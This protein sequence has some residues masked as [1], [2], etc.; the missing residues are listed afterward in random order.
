MGIKGALLS[1]VSLLSRHCFEVMSKYLLAAEQRTHVLCQVFHCSEFSSESHSAELLVHMFDPHYD[2]QT[3]GMSPALRR[4][5][6]E[7]NQTKTREGT[8]GKSINV[9]IDGETRQTPSE[10]LLPKQLTMAFK[11]WNT[12]AQADH[13]WFASLL[14]NR[15]NVSLFLNMFQGNMPFSLLEHD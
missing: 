11:L 15:S 13:L 9:R 7:K 6:G 5:C 8:W 14:C 3:K 4:N 12:I 2:P 1:A 10:L